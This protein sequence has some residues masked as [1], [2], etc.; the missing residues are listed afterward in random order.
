VGRLS[1]AMRAELQQQ[2]PDVAF[3]LAITIAGTTYRWGAVGEPGRIHAGT[4]LYE[5]RV[6]SWGGSIERGVSPTESGLDL[7]NDV[8]VLLNDH[9]QAITTILE[10]AARNSVRGATAVIYLASR[11]VGPG[12][13]LTLYSGRIETYSQPSPLLWSFRLAPHDQPLRRESVP[14]PKI[15]VSDW[16]TA[17][18][19]A[20][21]LPAPI[22]YGRVS[23]SN[24]T[25]DGAV[26]CHYVD[27]V[28]FRYLVCAG[29]A[30]AV[31][32]VYKDGVSVAAANYAITYP[33]VNGR[34]YTVIDFTATQ[35]T[36]TI[37]CDAQGYDS[38]GDGSGTLITDPAAIAKHLLVNWIYGDWQNGAWLSD[39]TAPVDV[40]SFGTTFFSTRGYEA[41]VYVATKRR[42]VDVLND[43]L[44]SF[45]AKACWTAAGTITLKV[46]DF[47][48]WSYVSDLVLREDEIS[49]WGLTYAV[50]QLVDKIELQYALLPTGGYTRR[51][52]VSDLGTGE[53]APEGIDAPF[54]PAFFL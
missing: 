7:S 36:S 46:E 33:V 31:E 14:K 41:S 21:D 20:R 34:L 28:G 54:S 48:S 5:P 9:D 50:A 32:T 40:T 51:L 29:R 8:D 18:L 39:S 15:L 16:P 19:A 42:G 26:A 1:A 3:L 24:G 44:K 22:L 35:G 53:Q 52:T 37:T 30:K 38:V 17:A 47:T 10:G 11:N 2:A 12:D 4:G 49:G 13:W 25:N 23:S 27:S 6:V 45:E 43:L